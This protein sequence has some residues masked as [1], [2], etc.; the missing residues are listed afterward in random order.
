MAQASRSPGR[1][2]RWMILTSTGTVE[3]NGR[4]IN[5]D[6]RYARQMN[7]FVLLVSPGRVPLIIVDPSTEKGCRSRP[8]ERGR[9]RVRASDKYKTRGVCA[10]V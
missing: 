2:E 9:I 10:R 3:V 7:K 1:P 8:G 5:R 6:S 4:A